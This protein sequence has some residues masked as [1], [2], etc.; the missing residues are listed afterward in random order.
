MHSCAGTISHFSTAAAPA[1]TAA[2]PFWLTVSS[3]LGVGGVKEYLWHVVT[4]EWMASSCR[5]KVVWF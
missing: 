5:L 2:V 3:P 1:A 4:G